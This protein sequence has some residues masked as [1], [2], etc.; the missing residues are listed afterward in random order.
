[1][2]RLDIRYLQ[3]D[4]DSGDVFTRSVEIDLDKTPDIGYVMA[5]IQHVLESTYDFT[6]LQLAVIEREPT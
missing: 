5:Q 3:E 2:E 4:A 6:G 1:M